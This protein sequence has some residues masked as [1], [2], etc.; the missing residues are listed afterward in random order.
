MKTSGYQWIKWGARLSLA[1]L[2]IFVTVFV[3]FVMPFE[4][5]LLHP[6]LLLVTTV[7]RTWLTLGVM[8][9]TSILILPPI[10][11][12]ITIAGLLSPVLARLAK[13]LKL[14]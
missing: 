2:T 3:I 12:L 8:L 1:Y 13:A 9:I 14:S 10:V 7:N 11:L 4:N 6:Q 5:G